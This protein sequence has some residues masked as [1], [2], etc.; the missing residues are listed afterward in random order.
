MNGT[1]VCHIR[2]L[3]PVVVQRFFQT[4]FD[5]IPDTGR[6][7]H[8]YVAAEREDIAVNPLVFRESDGDVISAV[9]VSGNALL[10]IVVIN[11]VEVL[12]L[13]AE[14]E[15]HLLE[16]GGGGFL[17]FDA[18]RR[19]AHE[20]CV[21]DRNVPDAGDTE[22]SEIATHLAIPPDVPRPAL[23][24]QQPGLYP[25]VAQNAV[26]V[27]IIAGDHPAFEDSAL[28]IEEL[29]FLVGAA[30]PGRELDLDPVRGRGFLE[31][32]PD[33]LQNRID[34]RVFGSL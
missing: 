10:V 27:D 21:G 19:P 13:E 18:V 32:R 28:D 26:R 11:A 30:A 22:S 24:K 16:Q 14:L 9:R 20:S 4:L 6:F 31:H 5:D 23:K 2:K 7:Q 34:F 15:G 8:F 25:A 17:I 3:F 33:F 1:T 12:G 29:V